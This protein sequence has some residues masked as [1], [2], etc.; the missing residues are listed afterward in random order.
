MKI[1]VTGG[2]GYIGSHTCLELLKAGEE[3]VVLDNLSNASLEGLKRVEELTGR[4]VDFHR[5][6]LLDIA[7]VDL[8]GDTVQ[9]GRR[10]ELVGGGSG[11]RASPGQWIT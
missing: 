7:E 8:G 1:L 3:V 4:K 11:D 9:I 10:T 6:D 5:V 2:A